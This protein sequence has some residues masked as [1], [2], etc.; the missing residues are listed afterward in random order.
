MNKQIGSNIVEYIIPV[1]LIGIVV[2]LSMFYM[3]SNGKLAGVFSASSG[4]ELDKES[5]KLTIDKNIEKDKPLVNIT[6]GSLGGTNSQPAIECK[7]NECNIDF[8]DYVLKGLPGDFNEYVQNTGAS[9]GTDKLASLLDQIAA[10]LEA[11]GNKEGS[12]EVK[13]LASYSH[14]MA[15]IEKSLETFV[16]GCNYDKACIQ[17][18]YKPTEEP[19][20]I[21]ASFPKPQGLDER[22]Y[23]FP[24]DATFHDAVYS[25]SVGNMMN[26]YNTWQE[27]YDIHK[28]Q[29][30]LTAPFV[31]QLI[32][33]QNS[34]YLDDKTKSIV[35]ELAWQIGVIG[36]DF[37]NQMAHISLGS[38]DTGQGFADPLVGGSTII[39]TPSDP[40]DEMKNYK[41]SKI[42]NIDAALMCAAGRNRDSGK[43]CH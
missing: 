5:G 21:D 6:P 7:D 9:G 1:A 29:G 23:K 39:E 32:G 24:E 38:S 22:F 14:N 33:I 35:E 43:Y 19:P 41:A 36:E 17:K 28:D 3:F 8:G 11:E 2:G 26:L 15:T 10:A 12:L 27:A 30:R 16:Q 40:V 25:V 31:E 34:S 13:K 4:T 37:Q 42:T 20:V 18:Q